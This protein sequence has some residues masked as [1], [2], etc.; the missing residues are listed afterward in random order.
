MECRRELKERQFSEACMLIEPCVG[1]VKVGSPDASDAQP[2][3]N[4]RGESPSEEATTCRSQLWD[5]AGN[6]G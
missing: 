3:P 6:R 1:V 2:M 5:T 4:K